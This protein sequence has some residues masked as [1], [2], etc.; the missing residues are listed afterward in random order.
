MQVARSVG[1][2]C[3]FAGSGGAIVVYCPGGEIQVASLREVAKDNGFNVAAVEV[4]PAN[5]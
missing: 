3:K 2:A 1:A 5:E 4:A